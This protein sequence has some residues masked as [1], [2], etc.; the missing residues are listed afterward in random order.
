ML[1]STDPKQEWVPV[2][3]SSSE[4]KQAASEVHATPHKPSVVIETPQLAFYTFSL[5]HFRDL[6]R[7]ASDPDIKRYLFWNQEFTDRQIK[8]MIH[9]WRVQQKETGITRW[10]V[11]R[12]SDKAFV[13]I[14]GFSQSP[15]VGGVE[16]SLGIMPEFRGDPLTKELYRALLHHGFTCLGL[17]RIFGLAQPQNIAIKRFESKFGFRFLRQILL[18]GTDLYDLSEL[19]AEDLTAHE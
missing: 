16:V 6:R 3:C 9:Y 1:T 17:D 8:A 14:C 11:Y 10:P 5:R 19:T 4:S 13:G 12:K 2:S 18:H 15:E 7:L